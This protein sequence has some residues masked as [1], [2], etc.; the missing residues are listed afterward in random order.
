MQV[1]LALLSVFLLLIL[2]II[3]MP[4]LFQVDTENRIYRVN[5]RGIFDFSLH[6]GFKPFF[7]MR[8]MGFPVTMPAAEEKKEKKPKPKVK[9]KKSFIKKS[10]RTWRGLLKGVIRSFRIRKLRCRINSGDF[11]LNAKL[12]SILPVLQSGN[13]D[14]Q[15][16]FVNHSLLQLELELRINRLI[17]SGIVF[18]FKK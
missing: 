1:L 13:S 14:I 4:V 6:P 16:D 17:W 12:F 11:V 10:F 9:K 8:I 15:V 2:W 5:Q 7:R 18:I 3:F